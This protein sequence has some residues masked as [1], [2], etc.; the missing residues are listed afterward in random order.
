MAYT[1][2]ILKTLYPPLCI[3]S[4]RILYP[5]VQAKTPEICKIPGVL[6]PVIYGN[7]QLGSDKNLK[8]Y[9]KQLTKLLLNIQPKVIKGKENQ[10][11]VEKVQE[12]VIEE[13]I[14]KAKRRWLL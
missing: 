6:W 14:I 10:V 9:W 3:V 4:T 8:N 13:E 12:T 2:G 11:V 5:R 1:P 7:S